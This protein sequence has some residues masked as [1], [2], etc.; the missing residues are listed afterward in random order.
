MTIL[1]IMNAVGLPGRVLSGLMADRALGPVNTLTAVCF[2]SGILLYSWSAVSSLNGLFA[3]CV[4]YGTL[5]SGVQGLFASSCASLTVDLNK[6]GVRTGMCFSMVSIACLTGP[7]ITGAL[8]QLNQGRFL[9]AQ[10]FGGSAFMI[11]TL[12]LM[13]AKVAKNGSNIGIRM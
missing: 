13:G 12:A 1:L 2:G 6:M 11:G 9:Y 8:V 7:P 5:A 3:F 4:I 10:I